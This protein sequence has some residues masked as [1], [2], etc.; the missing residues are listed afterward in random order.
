MTSL[1]VAI[2]DDEPLALERLSSMIDRMD[3]VELVAAVPSGKVLLDEV[4]AA[5]PDLVLLDIEMPHLDGFDVVEALSRIEWPAGTSPP[6]VIFVTAHPRFAVAA[7]DSGAIDFINKPARL[8]RLERAI[9][10]AGTARE[11]L[12]ARQRLG[13]LQ[14][15]L[16][17][18]KRLHGNFEP[19]GHLWVR[20][21]GATVRV[22]LPSIE[23]IQA[24]GEYVR[25]HCDANSYLERISLTSL[26]EQLGSAGFVR[27]HRSVM[28]NFRAVERLETGDWGRCLVRLLSGRQLPVGRTFRSAVREAQGKLRL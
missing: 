26:A 17:E 23:W 5:K 3:G 7:F 2:C 24:D 9:A 19:T 15:Q 10:R 22:P 6:L 11:N 18:L 20:R 27:I 12:E 16:D 13:E 14:T 21:P 25:I 4:L 28:V 1:R 8:T